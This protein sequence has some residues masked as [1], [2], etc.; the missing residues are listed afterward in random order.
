MK[1][2]AATWLHDRGERARF[3]F[4]QPDGVPVGSV[5]DIRWRR[6]GLR[7]HLDQAVAPVWDEGSEPV[8]G[9]SVPVDRDTLIRRWYV[10]RIRLDSEGTARRVRI[11]TEAFARPIEWFALGRVRDDGARSIDAGSGADC[12]FPQHPTRLPVGSR[13][14]QEGPGRARSSAGASAQAGR[15]PQGGVRPRCDPGVP[16]HRGPD[17]R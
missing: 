11:G 4:A 13:Q 15:R 3:D 5:V 16:R 10:H 1:A 7:V 6:G 14:G 2:A 8:P 12:A 17:R 9:M